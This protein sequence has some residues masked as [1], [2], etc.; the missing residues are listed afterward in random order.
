MIKGSSL[1]IQTG[2]D[3]S[4]MCSFIFYVINVRTLLDNYIRQHKQ[5][6]QCFLYNLQLK[7]YN[8]NL[9]RHPA[10]TFRGAHQL[11]VQLYVF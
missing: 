10:G 5:N 1:F 4:Q 2:I 8:S 7:Y 11:Y 3:E 6:A 9:F